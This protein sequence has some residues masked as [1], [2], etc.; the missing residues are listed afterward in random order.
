MV[1]V[2]LNKYS[3]PGEIIGVEEEFLPGFGVYVDENGFLRSQLVGRIQYDLVKRNI[4]IKHVRNKP[5]L[6]KQGDVVEGTVSS[7]SDDIVFIDIYGV[8]ETYYRVPIF[9]G[10]IHV[11]QA[12]S[13]YIGSMYDA[14]R[15]G[16]VVKARVLNNSN[17]YQLTT[18]DPNL[19][20]I[21][22]FCSKCGSTL[23]RDN[24]RL[25]CSNCGNIESRKISI[26]YVYRVK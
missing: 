4:S 8:N 24:E 3:F 1:A 21:I 9:S 11:S 14:Y 2:K 20:V 17:P 19:G 23:Y 25:V 6:P 16:E 15:L 10:I 7:V 13:Q 5:V 26:Q 22:A 18:K 12:S